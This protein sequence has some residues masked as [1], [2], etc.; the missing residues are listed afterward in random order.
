MVYN[1]KE[2]H[3]HDEDKNEVGII[4]LGFF[5]RHSKKIKKIKKSNPWQVP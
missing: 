4:Y 3:Q 2:N 5:S 1:K